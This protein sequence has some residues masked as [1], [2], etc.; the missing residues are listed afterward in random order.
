MHLNVLYTNTR[1]IQSVSN[2]TVPITQISR[3][4]QI[5]FTYDFSC[6][7]LQ[8]KLKNTQG[9]K[10]NSSYRGSSYRNSVEIPREPD[11]GT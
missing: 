5:N 4:I 3:E 10:K 2:Y 8:T 9:S 7:V 1:V 6:Y 11:I